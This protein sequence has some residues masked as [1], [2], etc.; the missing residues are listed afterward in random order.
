MWVANRKL[1]AMLQTMSSS[2]R[3][4]SML[5]FQRPE[6]YR[7]AMCYVATYPIIVARLIKSGIKEGGT[8]PSEVP[9][10]RFSLQKDEKLCQQQ[11]K[12]SI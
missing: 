1:G 12:Q 4:F 6:K 11:P 8:V 7:K 10:E 9:Q 2:T 5:I 3:F